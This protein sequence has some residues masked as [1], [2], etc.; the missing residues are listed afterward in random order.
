M[1]PK[2]PDS[3]IHASEASVRTAG[4]SEDAAVDAWL[5]A[6]CLLSVKAFDSKRPFK[7]CSSNAIIVPLQ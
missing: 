4:E 7:T 2:D 3:K 6:G 1:Y 5:E